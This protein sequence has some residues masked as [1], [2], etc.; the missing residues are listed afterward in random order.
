M[1]G[2]FDAGRQG[3]LGVVDDAWVQIQQQGL[4]GVTQGNRTVFVVDMGSRVGY[5]G[6]RAGAAAGN[7]ALTRIQLV[8]EK[9]TSNVITAFPVQ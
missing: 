7:P 8:V 2:V 9:G 6:G 3:A 1:H 4:Q 5:L